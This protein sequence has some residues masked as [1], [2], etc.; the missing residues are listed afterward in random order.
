MT[1]NQEQTNFCNQG[2]LG[3]RGWDDEI[4]PKPYLKN[5]NLKFVGIRGGSIEIEAK[6][7]HELRGYSNSNFNNRF[8]VDESRIAKIQAKISVEDFDY[9]KGFA[10][11]NKKIDENDP[12]LVKIRAKISEEDVDYLRGL[13][14]KRFGVNN[15][16]LAKIRANISEENVVGFANSNSNI[17]FGA[18][19]NNARYFDSNSNIRFGAN[20]NNARFFDNN[21]G[22]ISMCVIL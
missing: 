4:N 7:D 3:F 8:D 20:P 22:T 2:C 10:N 18:D 14:N 5:N 12:R 16:G 13:A 9:L 21:V 1:S 19:P 15:T 11:S 6:G 17:R